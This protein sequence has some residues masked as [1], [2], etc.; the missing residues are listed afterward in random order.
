MRLNI[1]VRNQQYNHC[2]F[3]HM[4]HIIIKKNDIRRS[5]KTLSRKTAHL[6]L[7]H[8]I[9]K[10]SSSILIHLRGQNN[11]PIHLLRVQELHDRLCTPPFCHVRFSA[12][13]LT[14]QVALVRRVQRTLQG[15]KESLNGKRE[16]HVTPYFR[17][18][19][20]IHH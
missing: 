4:I 5:S 8:C 7:Y 1:L 10:H 20:Q 3:N 16:K 11:T 12:R 14:I 9:G 6:I 13:R 15:V 2:Y 18:T 17:R 19:I